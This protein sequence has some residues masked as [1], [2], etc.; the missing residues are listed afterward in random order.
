MPRKRTT[1]TD[2]K[3]RK[4][5]TDEQRDTMLAEVAAGASHR[6]VAEKHGVH[7]SM[8]YYWNRRKAEGVLNEPPPAPLAKR[9]RNSA[10]LSLQH[11]NGNT[12]AFVNS[13]PAIPQTVQIA[14]LQRNN[15]ILKAIVSQ[16]LEHL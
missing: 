4:K 15:G 7:P 11:V 9:K 14:L 2:A 5:Y 1:A 10:Q 12:P 6:E 16:L 13:G 3:P 8:I